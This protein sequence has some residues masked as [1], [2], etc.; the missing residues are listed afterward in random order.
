M[1]TALALL[2]LAGCNQTQPGELGNLIFDDN[3]SLLAPGDGAFVVGDELVFSGVFASNVVASAT[4]FTLRSSDESV[5]Q[6][7][8][9]PAFIGT[10]PLTFRGAVVGEGEANLEVIN[11]DTLAVIDQISLRGAALSSVEITDEFLGLLGGGDPF[12]S[13]QMIP[14]YEM[15]LLACAVSSVGERLK[16]QLPGGVAVSNSNAK[17]SMEDAEIGSS[18]FSSIGEPLV[19]TAQTPGN[20]ELVVVTASTIHLFDVQVVSPEEVTIVT[21]IP[22]QTGA[23]LFEGTILVD[24]LLSDGNNIEGERYNIEEICAS[25]CLLRLGSSSVSESTSFRAVASGTATLRISLLSA[26]E[27]P[28]KEELFEV[29]VIGQ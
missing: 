15:R 29:D 28:L 25:S 8:A 23:P 3:E 1:R 9:T 6:F 21:S 7:D 4:Q 26:D 17:V 12:A 14:G 24:S 11:A 16:G 10:R 22:E 18:R 2:F 5:L 13:F 20:T 27:E 19:L